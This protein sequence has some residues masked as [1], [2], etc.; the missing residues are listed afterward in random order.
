MLFVVCCLL[1]VVC[2][3]LFVVDD[4]DDDDVVVVDVVV[5]VIDATWVRLVIGRSACP[6]KALQ[7]FWDE[8]KDTEWFQQHPVLKA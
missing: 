2:C 1:F 8:E 3:L 5:D 7:Q 4:D 6:N